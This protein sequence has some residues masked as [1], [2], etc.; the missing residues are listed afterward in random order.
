[1][2]FSTRLLACDWYMITEPSPE[3]IADSLLPSPSTPNELRLAWIV[4]F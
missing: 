4:L 2:S 3:T 1:M